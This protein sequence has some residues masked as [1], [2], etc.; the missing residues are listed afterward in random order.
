MSEVKAMRYSRPPATRRT[1][2]AAAALFLGM[3]A[4]AAG[5]DVRA[6]PRAATLVSSGSTDG[7]AAERVDY[8]DVN[9]ASVRGQRT[10][11]RRLHAAAR[12]VCQVPSGRVRLEEMRA[13]QRC[14]SDSLGKA[15][16]AVGHPEVTALFES[17]TL[18]VGPS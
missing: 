4:L 18:S 9:L 5:A 16:G 10:L 8:S 13:A 1:T 11:L 2:A 14:V 6:D 12:R 15:V 17:R 7:L 3:A